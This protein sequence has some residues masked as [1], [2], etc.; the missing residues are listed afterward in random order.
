MSSFAGNDGDVQ[1]EQWRCLRRM[2][3]LTSPAGARHV[4]VQDGRGADARRYSGE[5]VI[6][7]GAHRTFSAVDAMLNDS[8]I[9]CDEQS[10]GVAEG[11]AT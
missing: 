6:F 9:A 11:E 1:R 5:H 10:Q 8:V 7:G 4:G 3:V 2:K